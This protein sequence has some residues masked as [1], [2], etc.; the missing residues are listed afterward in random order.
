MMVGTLILARR[1]SSIE[2]SIETLGSQQTPHLAHSNGSLPRC[3]NDT[4]AETLELQLDA[5]EHTRSTNT[6]P[7]LLPVLGEHPDNAT[8]VIDRIS[9]SVVA[10]IEDLEGESPETP[11]M[12]DELDTRTWDA[13]LLEELVQDIYSHKLYMASP[14]SCRDIREPRDR[15]TY[16]RQER[17]I[18]LPVRCKE[19]REC[20]SGM[21]TRAFSIDPERGSCPT[22]MESSGHSCILASSPE[23]NCKYT[24]VHIPLRLGYSE[25]CGVM[26]ATGVPFDAN[27]TS[28][29][30]LTT[31]NKDTR[32]G[33]S[34]AYL[35]ERL[36]SSDCSCASALSPEVSN[37][38]ERGS[39]TTL[40]GAVNTSMSFRCG[41]TDD[42]ADGNC[43]PYSRKHFRYTLDFVSLRSMELGVCSRL[44]ASEEGSIHEF[45]LSRLD[46]YVR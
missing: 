23:T 8:I 13:D 30:S 35:Y 42:L 21:W 20:G 15:W 44:S 36:E 11:H 14:D 28:T 43:G 18:V 4:L 29:V 7:R 27:A 31:T 34:V 46:V 25:I 16:L 40:S 19:V 1:L 33:I 37:I 22:G 12:V 38:L 17:G 32:K 39:Q 45:H 5:L 2:S 41:N 3:I 26:T 6:P 10:E 9:D 24:D